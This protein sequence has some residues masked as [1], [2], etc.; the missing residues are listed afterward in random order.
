MGKSKGPSTQET[1]ERL[2]AVTRQLTNALHMVQGQKPNYFRAMVRLLRAYPKML[3]LLD[4]E[5]EYMTLRERDKSVT[6]APPPGG[7][8][9]DAYTKQEERLEAKRDAWETT[10]QQFHALD[11]VVRQFENDPR[12]V[13]VSMY[14]FGADATGVIRERERAYTWEEICDELSATGRYVSERTLRGWRSRIIQE[15]VVLIFGKDGALNL[16]E[17]RGRV[18]N[19]ESTY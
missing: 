15:M 1:V 2:E 19:N 3:A 10:L 16:E 11:S 14:D 6:V 18:E 12:F 17:P 9:K 13:A 5:E 4:D 7:E 8:V